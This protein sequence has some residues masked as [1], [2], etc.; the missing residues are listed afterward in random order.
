MLPGESPDSPERIPELRS[1]AATQGGARGRAADVISATLLSRLT[2][3]DVLRS[4]EF[5]ISPD[6][7]VHV[8]LRLL[9]DEDGPMLEVLKTAQDATL[10]VPRRTELQPDAERLAIRF[11]RFQQAS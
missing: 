1:V 4:H 2:L 8:S 6:L 11:E 9:D 10:L 3:F 7:R 5:G